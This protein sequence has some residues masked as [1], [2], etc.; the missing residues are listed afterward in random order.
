MLPIAIIAQTTIFI[1]KQFEHR[2]DHFATGDIKYQGK[3]VNTNCM[4]TQ[5]WNPYICTTP[6]TFFN[7]LA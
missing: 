6:Q 7:V 3:K 2:R 1:K 5:Q 4:N